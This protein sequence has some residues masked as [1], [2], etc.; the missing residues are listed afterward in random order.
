MLKKRFNNLFPIIIDL[1]TTGTNPNEDA[2]LEI[3]LITIKYKLNN[4]YPNKIIHYHIDPFK[5]L[6]FNKKSLDFN[7]IIPFHPFRYAI[8][9]HEALTNIFNFIK[10]EI[11]LTKF[12][13]SIL[14]GHNIYFDLSF[15]NSAIK[16]NN[17]KKNP[18]HTF[19]YLD[20]STLGLLIFKEHILYKI[21]KKANIKSNSKDFHSALYDAMKTAELFCNIINK[22]DKKI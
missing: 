16:R 1:E 4:I 10:K 11:A 13:K 20:T 6:N 8:S 19:T 5:I 18:F 21:L 12:K 7:K 3:A 17:I 2:I 9:E 22:Y 14:I 15:L